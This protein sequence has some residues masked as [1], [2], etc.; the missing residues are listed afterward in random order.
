MLQ[1]NTIALKILQTGGWHIRGVD[2]GSLEKQLHLSCQSGF[3]VLRPNRA[4]T[5][6]PLLHNYTQNRENNT[7]S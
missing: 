6:T 5:L 3:Q 4:G 2:V 1:I 7:F